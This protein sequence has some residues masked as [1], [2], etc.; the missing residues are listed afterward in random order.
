MLEGAVENGA[1]ECILSLRRISDKTIE[2]S[3]H[4]YWDP[5]IQLVSFQKFHEAMKLYGEE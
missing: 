3:P 4:I 1:P 5:S 2:V